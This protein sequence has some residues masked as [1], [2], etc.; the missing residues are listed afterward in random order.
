MCWLPSAIY[1]SLLRVYPFI[2]QAK[3]PEPP[4]SPES[5]IDNRGEP[6]PLHSATT[7]RRGKVGTRN[8]ADWHPEGTDGQTG[9]THSQETNTPPP[10]RSKHQER[11]KKRSERE[12]DKKSARW[13]PVKEEMGKH[14]KLMVGEPDRREVVH[15]EGKKHRASLFGQD[16]RGIQP[17]S[18]IFESDEMAFNPFK[19][20]FGGLG[21]IGHKHSTTAGCPRRWR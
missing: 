21:S 11:K 9:K 8:E 3:V 14:R 4:D 18:N 17:R 19:R 10:S 5:P 6:S 7:E 2:N 16:I 13:K 20:L 1:T 15:M 12:K